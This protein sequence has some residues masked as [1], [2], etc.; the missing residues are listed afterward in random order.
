MNYAQFYI[1]EQFRDYLRGMV[2]VDNNKTRLITVPN[3]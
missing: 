1:N 2:E 3:I